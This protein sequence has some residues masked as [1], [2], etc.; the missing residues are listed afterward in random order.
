MKSR[1][2]NGLTVV[3]VLMG[4]LAMLAAC[5]SDDDDRVSGGVTEDAGFVADVAGVAQK[6]PFVKGSAVT[7]RGID[8]KTLEFTDE[9]YEGVIKSDKGD[10]VI[11]S[12]ASVGTR[13]RHDGY[14]VMEIAAEQVHH[15]VCT[16]R[17]ESS[18]LRL[19]WASCQRI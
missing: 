16:D 9:N 3:S 13:N 6:G 19:A 1:T 18:H 10:F 4:V 17:S 7:V 12:V 2:R 8:C 5:S 14:S 11:D 15:V